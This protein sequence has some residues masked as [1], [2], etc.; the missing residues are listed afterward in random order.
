LLLE[1]DGADCS[2]LV[3]GPTRSYMNHPRN[4][5]R[6]HPRG[7]ENRN[8]ASGTP[9]IPRPPALPR[10]SLPQESADAFDP[11][12]VASTA[13]RPIVRVRP[14]S[15]PIVRKKLA[16]DAT[17]EVQVED[18][19]L[20]VY[21][22]EPAPPR[23]RRSAGSSIDA[24]EARQSIAMAIASM[25]PPAPAQSA[26][27]DALLRASDPSFAPFVP[28]AH[29]G[30]ADYETPSVGPMM[31]ATAPPPARP[32]LGDASDARAAKARRRGVALAIW[33][34]VI[35]VIGVAAGGAMVMAVRNGSY[36]HLRDGAKS[37]ALRATTKH[38][39]PVSPAAAAA[40]VTA[41]PAP[42]TLAPPSQ[43]VVAPSAPVAAVT[44]AP[45]LT[46]SIDALPKPAVPADASFVT[47]PP[48]AQG[49]RIFLDGR[50]LPVVEGTPTKIKCGRHMLKIGSGRKPHIVDFACGRDVIVQ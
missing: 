42:T 17:S 41:A 29:H 14:G 20:E 18:I 16:A 5:T 12:G 50:V 22:E 1:S 32:M 4:H 24:V 3:V 15:R 9:C 35:M 8:D 48:Y 13:Q 49:H 28:R 19:L 37:A 7:P 21:A 33:A 26:A 44:P 43:A 39:A 6:H 46:V 47:F 40:P 10:F 34:T 2:R 30:G 25:V 36:A 11:L 45:V 27:V 23:T 38:D 31:I